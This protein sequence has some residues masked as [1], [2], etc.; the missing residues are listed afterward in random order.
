MSF[1]FKK[2]GF[3]S[4]P[5]VTKD[6]NIQTSNYETTYW[7]Y[8]FILFYQSFSDKTSLLVAIFPTKRFSKCLRPYCFERS[9]EELGLC[10]IMELC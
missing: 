4:Q 3:K 7:K 9:P 2:L 8:V 10:S 6:F 5:Y 1:S